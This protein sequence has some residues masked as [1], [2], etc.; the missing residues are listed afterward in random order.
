MDKRPHDM[1]KREIVAALKN[2]IERMNDEQR[3][4]LLEHAKKLLRDAQ[5]GGEAG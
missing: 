2:R 4:E 1:T 3:S 5:G